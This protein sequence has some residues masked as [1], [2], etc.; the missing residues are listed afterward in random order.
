M[1]SCVL[2]VNMNSSCAF[3][4]CVL[5]VG[6]AADHSAP[7][8]EAPH[9]KSGYGHDSYAHSPP[10]YSFKYGVDAPGKKHDGK[11][12]GYSGPLHFGHTEDRDGYATKGHYYVDLPDGRR[13]M[14][15]YHVADDYSG[16]VADVKYEKVHEPVHSS[17]YK[18]DGGYHQYKE[19]I[20]YIL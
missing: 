3:A 17:G 18:H 19:R 12:G 7:H 9:A 1:G 15:T 2:T 16:Y 11:Y 20:L 4:L 8:H 6:V 10:H 5:L 13:Q 14:V